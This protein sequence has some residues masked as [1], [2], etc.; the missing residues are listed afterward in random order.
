MLGGGKIYWRR[1]KLITSILLMRTLYRHFPGIVR[2]QMWLKDDYIFLNLMQ[3]IV[4]KVLLRP[5]S[6]GI[7]FW[8][9]YTSKMERVCAISRLYPPFLEEISGERDKGRN[10]GN[11]GKA[12]QVLETLFRF[13]QDSLTWHSC[14]CKPRDNFHLLSMIEWIRTILHIMTSFIHCMQVFGV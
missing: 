4:L 5:F 9:L 3:L 8:L 10:K 11:W 12:A 6:L 13:I 2:N 1:Q 14:A 7:S